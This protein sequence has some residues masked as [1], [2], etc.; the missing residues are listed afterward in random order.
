MRSLWGSILA[1]LV[2]PE[3]TELTRGGETVHECNSIANVQVESNGI[4]CIAS[5][6]LSA[7]DLLVFAYACAATWLHAC[8]AS[9]RKSKSVCGSDR[10]RHTA[11]TMIYNLPR[12]MEQVGILFCGE[13]VVIHVRQ[14][15]D[16][17]LDFLHT[18]GRLDHD[19]R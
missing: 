13:N 7:I 12:Q 10:H 8:V 14:W 6:S 19:R 5:S 4:D 16:V 17:A 1:Q 9:P 18:P 11:H 2:R 3:P 15:R